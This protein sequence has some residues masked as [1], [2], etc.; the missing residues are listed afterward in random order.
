M[1]HRRVGPPPSS[2]RRQARRARAAR[3]PPWVDPW[4]VRRTTTVELIVIRR[5][6]ATAAGSAVGGFSLAP[7][8]AEAVV[9]AAGEAAVGL[10]GGAAI[11]PLVDV[12]DLEELLGGV[13]EV[14]EAL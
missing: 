9:V 2:I 5:G 6:Q 7:L 8:V 14:V 12:V 3:A 1:A 11:A 13:A 4:W 10:D